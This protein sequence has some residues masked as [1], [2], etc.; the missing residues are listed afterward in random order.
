M[1]RLAVP[2]VL[3]LMLDGNNTNAGSGGPGLSSI[4]TGALKAAYCGFPAVRGGIEGKKAREVG[5]AS[6]RSMFGIIFEVRASLEV[7]S[8]V[9]LTCNVWRISGTTILWLAE[10]FW[11]GL[12][13][14]FAPHAS[15]AGRHVVRSN[16]SVIALSTARMNSC[17]CTLSA[18]VRFALQAPYGHTQ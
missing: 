10:G 14:G 18:L 8:Y 12:S 11:H 16:L 3:L 17:R 2:T 4:R 1:P 6:C 13:L 15:R 9:K 5:Y 7:T